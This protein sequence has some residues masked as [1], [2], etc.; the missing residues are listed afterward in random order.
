M[1]Q[2]DT[3]GQMTSAGIASDPTAN[4][5]VHEIQANI[6]QTR[7]EMSE[8]INEL[9]E[10]LSPA[11][12][13]E[14]LKDQVRE[15]YA[16]AKETVRGATIGKVE[17]MV[18]RFSDSVYETRR[19][20]VDTISANPVPSALIGIGLAWLWMNRRSESQGG[21]RRY[22]G[23]SRSS[24]RY[25]D[26]EYDHDYGTAGTYPSRG[27]Y[28]TGREGGSATSWARKTGEAVSGAAGRV[29]ETASNLAG[30]A[31][32]TVTGAVGQ[33]QATAGEWM[34]QAQQQVHR[35]EERLQG[36][37][38]ENPLALGAVA[39]ALGTAIG[40]AVPTTR[41]EREWMGE[42][43]DRLLDQAQSVAH[44]TIEQVQDVAEKVTAEMAG[45][46]QSGSQRGEG[47]A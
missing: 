24:G 29:Q 41:K 21:N 44:D 23:G 15:Q 31:K 4:E 6:A 33:A 30:R 19:T 42:A 11:H 10:R 16:H 8:T 47:A 35:V 9:Q 34:G 18:E 17:D 26:R 37:L 28:D 14:Q 43:R 39:V 12:L 27:A 3:T 46:R 20:I 22:G 13:K 45:S 38:Q 7:A 1:S 5:Q 25:Y 2:N 40:L 36:S 32:E